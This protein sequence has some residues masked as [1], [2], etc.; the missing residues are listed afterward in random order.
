MSNFF[1]TERI[2]DEYISLNS[3]GIQKFYDAD[4]NCLREKG[5][6]DYHILYVSEGVCHLTLKGVKKEV[7]RGNII[8]FYPNEPQQYSFYA[9]EK[10]VS[11]FIHFTGTGCESIL[12]KLNPEKE[13]VIHI[14]KNIQFE[15]LFE[16]LIKEH[17]LKQ[18]FYE[19]YCSGILVELL[20]EIARYSSI[21]KNR[22]GKK[23]EKIIDTARLEIHKNLATV[24]ISQLASQCFLSTGRFSHIF[25]EVTGIPPREYINNMRIQKAKDMISYTDYPI[26]HIARDVGIDDQ[27]Y[28]SRIFKKHTGISPSEY[29]KGV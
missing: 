3:C 13:N 26:S 24:T 23:N 4:G 25:K 11:Y 5:R 15:D 7:P 20:S 29:R 28:F 16:K 14:G 19:T 18:Q 22:I 1:S 17:A 21:K 6:I 10:S 27:N 8:L 2:T 12:H 9:S